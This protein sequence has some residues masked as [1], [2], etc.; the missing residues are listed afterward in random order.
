MIIKNAIFLKNQRN[1]ELLGKSEEDPVSI[2]VT[3]DKTMLRTP[4][5]FTELLRAGM[6]I[7][8]INLAHDHSIWKSLVE[9]PS[10]PN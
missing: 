10:G 6:T 2:M 1:Q 4:E 3:L 5:I 7:A 9:L 8:R